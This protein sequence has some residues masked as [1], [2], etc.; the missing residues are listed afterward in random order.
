MPATNTTPTFHPELVAAVRDEAGRAADRVAGFLNG[1]ADRGV[2]M[3]PLSRDTLLELAAAL[4]LAEWERGGLT[5]HAAAGLPDARTAAQYALATVL[6]AVRR[7]D[8]GLIVHVVGLFA[9]RLAW[10]AQAELG[11]DVVLDA[12]DEDALIEHL[13]RFLWDRRHS[14]PDTP[15]N[16]P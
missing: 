6:P 13:A 7:L 1:L 12:P 14:H 3:P 8:P 9:D 4:T 11:A 5:V 2:T 15:R 16:H 10:H